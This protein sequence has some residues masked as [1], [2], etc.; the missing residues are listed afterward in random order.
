M[1]GALALLGS[2]AAAAP[3]RVLVITGQNN[4]DWVA[5]T[6]T[7]V[8]Q[9]EE[10]GRFEV[11]VTESPMGM[12]LREFD[13]YDAIVSNFNGERLGES[14]ERDLL[15]YL[16][17]GGGIV[18]I[19]AA[20]NSWPGWDDFDSL[21]GIAWREGAGHGTRHRYVVTLDK[22]EHPILRGMPHFLHTPD[23][24]YHRL[25]WWPESTAEVIATAYSR[26][27]EGGTGLFEPAL[28]VN[29]WGDGRMFH[30]IMGH[31]NVS[32]E[33]PW[34]ALLLQRGT[35]WAATGQVTV[36]VPA[37]MPPDTLVDPDGAAAEEKWRGLGLAEDLTAA[38]TGALDPEDEAVLLAPV[39]T[40]GPEAA[41]VTAR[42]RMVR[43]GEPSIVPLMDILAT[44]EEPLASQVR[45]DLV[46][47]AGA[48]PAEVA[49]PWLVETLTEYTDARSPSSQRRCAAAMLGQ[50]GGAEALR[51]LE[52]LIADPVAGLDAMAALA[53]CPDPAATRALAAA[54]ANDDAATRV[55]LLKAL[56]E[57]GDPWAARA[58]ARQLEHGD[59]AV[60]EA[61]VRALGGLHG[62]AA[63]SAL[64]K[65]VE[66]GEVPSEESLVRVGAALARAGE[67]EEAWG[68][69]YPL[70]DPGV[71]PAVR[72]RAFLA[73]R[74]LPTRES[75]AVLAKA[76]LVTHR[77]A[78]F[79]ALAAMDHPWATEALLGL[80]NAPDSAVSVSALRAL[81]ERGDASAA[82]GVTEILADTGRT[83][84]ERIAAA[85]ALGRLAD[86]DGV[87]ALQATLG[88]P[89][90]DALREACARALVAVGARRPDLAVSVN[91][92]ALQGF[93][94]DWHLVGA[95]PNQAGAGLA[96]AYPP[97]S[98]VDLAAGVAYDGATLEWKPIHTED[99]QGRFGLREHFV[100]KDNVVAYAYTEVTVDE[101]MDATMKIGSD[102]GNVVWVNGEKVFSIDAAR[103]LAVDQDVFAVHLN[104]GVNRILVKIVQGGGDWGFCVRLV[105][106]D[107]KAVGVSGATK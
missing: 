57:R 71:E 12:S 50:V 62:N 25:R 99:A 48:M 52:A 5:T 22:P 105:G 21:I 95:F 27:E 4:H 65:R 6:P 90:D 64:R 23:E 88:S 49:P 56:G 34:H 24:L 37:D 8:R 103:P 33:N 31:D 7:L 98:E 18:I 75:V 78:A 94:T 2:A 84:D 28:L 101:A 81:G 36:P 10:T 43:I 91:L 15:A 102:D 59:A 92:A 72:D 97:E 55:A 73:M 100:V 82:G 11:T 1:L 107:G 26:P 66:A 69:L 87:T 41:R 80:L 68:A 77:E 70:T 32:L 20:D 51:T 60:Q 76:A 54:L 3:L 40:A 46:A 74:F 86:A 19:H 67:A 106:A 14:T 89:V 30:T 35:E 39:I 104:P 13:A 47:I 96:A 79:T 16:E 61:A 58:V 38:V 53:A 44:A 42:Q 83:A 93:L 45:S 63:V 17:G 29:R 9:L 85:T